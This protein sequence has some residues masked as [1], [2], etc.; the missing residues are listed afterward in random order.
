MGEVLKTWVIN[1]VFVVIFLIMLE[2][3]L[4]NNSFKKYV[5]IIVGLVLIIVIIRPIVVAIKGD[6]YITNK[7]YKQLDAYSEYNIKKDEKYSES[8]KEYIKETYISIIKN[9]IAKYV[10]T[11][12]K[13]KV[14]NIDI[15]LQDDSNNDNNFNM[16]S[17]NILLTNMGH[18]KSSNE[19]NIE[20][21]NININKDNSK[22]KKIK[23]E[24]LIKALSSNYGIKE[25][26]ISLYLK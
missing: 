21:V 6:L 16:E 18:K 9:N 23:S 25:S 1:I 24:S 22:T 2:S 17:L 26:R 7:C 19:I 12:S 20:K 14:E 5:K 3:L 13:Y 10:E 8:Q 4:P 15:K 11:N